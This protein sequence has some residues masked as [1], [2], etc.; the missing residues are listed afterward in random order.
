MA[1]FGLYGSSLSLQCNGFWFIGMA[2]AFQIKHRQ[3]REL[4]FGLFKSNQAPCLICTWRS[5]RWNNCVFCCQKIDVSIAVHI[6]P[7]NKYLPGFTNAWAYSCV[8]LLSY[9]EKM[10][11][12]RVAAARADDVSWQYIK[13]IL[14]PHR[15][16]VF[17]L[18]YRL[19]HLDGGEGGRVCCFHFLKRSIFNSFWDEQD[20][21]QIFRH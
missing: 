2:F 18:L 5:F 13:R 20:C 15:R 19:R 8:C 14:P 6:V 12:E 9:A 21:D 3:K 17:C 7:K 10:S 16:M 4:I 1:T 11:K